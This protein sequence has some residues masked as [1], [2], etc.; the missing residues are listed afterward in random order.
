MELSFPVQWNYLLRLSGIIFFDLVALSSSAQWIYFLRITVLVFFGLLL[1][2]LYNITRCVS[3]SMDSSS[4]GITGTI[5]FGSLDSSSSAYWI[6]FSWDSSYKIHLYEYYWLTLIQHYPRRF[7]SLDLS[8]RII[9]GFIFF[10]G[11]IFYI[12]GFFGSMD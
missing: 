2:H 6:S 1:V 5:F 3:G 12:T 10:G 4:M 11:F 7:G 8:S 9:T